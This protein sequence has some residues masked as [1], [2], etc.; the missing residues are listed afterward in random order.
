MAGHLLLAVFSFI[1][2]FRAAYST[3]TAQQML[4]AVS[5]FSSDFTWPRITEVA[6][7]LGYYYS[8]ASYLTERQCPDQLH[9]IYS[10]WY[11]Y[12]RCLHEV[13]RFPQHQHPQS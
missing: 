8:A 13:K 7:V 12:P 1:V 10:R 2:Y 11:V 6:Y 9:R 5:Q 4:A 3:V